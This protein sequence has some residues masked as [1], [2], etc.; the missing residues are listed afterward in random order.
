MLQS[1][2]Q[3]IDGY[4][5]GELSSKAVMMVNSQDIQAINFKRRNEPICAAWPGLA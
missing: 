3:S 4:P 5:S 2:W 1:S